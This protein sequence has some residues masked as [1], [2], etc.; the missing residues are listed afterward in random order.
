MNKYIKSNFL[1]NLNNIFIV[2]NTMEFAEVQV[3][4]MLLPYSIVTVFV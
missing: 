2:I 3:L 1:Q 4:T